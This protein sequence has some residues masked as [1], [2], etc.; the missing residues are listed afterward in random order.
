MST[1]GQERVAALQR[2]RHVVESAVEDSLQV[3]IQRAINDEA[4]VWEEQFDAGLGIVCSVSDASVVAARLA[5]PELERLTAEVERLRSELNAERD[6]YDTRLS[7]LRAVKDALC[8]LF[9]DAEVDKL[10]IHPRELAPLVAAEVSRL[11]EQLATATATLGELVILKDGPRDAS[12]H[13][14][15]PLAWQ[16][17]RVF[18]AGAP[19]SESVPAT[20]PVVLA[21]PDS[22]GVGDRIRVGIWDSE[23]DPTEKSPEYVE[24]VVVVSRPAGRNFVDFRTDD[25]RVLYGAST[26]QVTERA[27]PPRASAPSEAS[28]EDAVLF[29]VAQD[30]VRRDK[31][32]RHT[33]EDV[34]EELELLDEGRPSGSGAAAPRSGVELIADERARQVAVEGWTPDHDATHNSDDLAMAAACYALP[35]S[36]REMRHWNHNLAARVPVFWPWHPE[37]WKSTGEDRVR[38]LV[39]AGALLAAEI[40]RIQQ[41]DAAQAAR[42]EATPEEPVDVRWDWSPAAE[43]SKSIAADMAASSSSPPSGGDSDTTPTEADQCQQV[44]DGLQCQE[45]SMKDSD[46]C[47]AHESMRRAINSPSRYLPRTHALHDDESDPE[48]LSCTEQEE[49]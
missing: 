43:L 5:A 22:A 20:P 44:M 41:Q 25:G 7:E 29:A 31:G 40:D 30:R 47:G 32:V 15:K 49:K 18:L 6:H 39:K 46:L 38:D 23:N 24:G 45:W 21:T 33:L 11:R 13:E 8:P 10:L 19:V 28:M 34:A 2:L 42:S 36:K 35:A 14:R 48:V 16:A 37:C 26:Y 17:A 27:D 3:R 1:E 4:P 12:Y 9:T